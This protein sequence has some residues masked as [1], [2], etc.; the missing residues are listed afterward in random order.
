MVGVFKGMSERKN[1]QNRLKPG[2][3]DFLL[4]VGVREDVPELSGWHDA[5]GL[6]GG[7]GGGV[8]GV[9][10]RDVGGLD[11]GVGYDWRCTTFIFVFA[12]RETA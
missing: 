1:L 7:L 4:H 11:G 8:C 5:P 2:R 10:Q 9:R 12:Q 3:G 6:R